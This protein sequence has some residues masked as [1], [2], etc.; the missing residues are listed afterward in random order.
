MESIRGEYEK[1]GAR[2]F[3][4]RHGADYRNPHEPIIGPC[5]REAISRW[6]LDLS[7]VLDLAAGSG[8]ATV[9]LR[10][11]GA[12]TVYGV[13]PYTAEAYRLRT[14]QEAEK[15]TFADIAAGGLS[16]RQYS[17]IVCSFAL[18][19]CEASRLAG[20]LY[21]LGQTGKVLLV[22]TP[23]KRPELKPEWGWDLS[24]EFVLERVRTRVYRKR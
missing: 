9:A 8:E 14:G 11:L 12:G 2:E 3:Y 19:L 5:I 22:L 7:Q 13:D 18:H 24:G 10:E 4:E 17:L 15:L 16:S 21:E 23:H 1:H 20:L 6:K